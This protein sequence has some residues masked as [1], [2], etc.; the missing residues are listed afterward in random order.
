MH[1]LCTKSF[2]RKYGRLTNLPPSS[3]RRSSTRP[4]AFHSGLRF[5][6]GPH[7]T[8]L[9]VRPT[10]I[11]S[12]CSGLGRQGRRRWQGRAQRARPRAC[13]RRL[14]RYR[15][16][17]SPF[18]ELWSSGGDFSCG[19]DSDEFPVLRARPHV[20]KMQTSNDHR[21]LRCSSTPHSGSPGCLLPEGQRVL[22]DFI[23]FSCW[24]WTAE[25]GR[26][27]GAS[28]RNVFAAAVVADAVAMPS[29]TQCD[30]LDDDAVRR[31]GVLY[32][33]SGSNGSSRQLGLGADRGPQT[34]AGGAKRRT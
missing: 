29:L 8:S 9:P 31:H 1:A 7:P 20:S 27:A 22:P 3:S 30:G 10:S 17:G 28:F 25:S 13:C 21:L 2:R 26:N 12:T 32:A 34:G 11:L 33:A 16:G 19:S 24:S 18:F 4:S 14:H 5:P 15:F 6:A 23:G